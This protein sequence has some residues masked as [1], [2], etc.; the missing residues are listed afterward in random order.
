MTTKKNTNTK[1]IF[2]LIYND[3]TAKKFIKCFEKSSDE[4]DK[5]IY[6]K[7]Y[8]RHDNNNIDDNDDDDDDD[9]V[10]DDVS[11][12]V[13]VIESILTKVIEKKLWKM[14]DDKS[15]DFYDRDN[16]N[17][18]S[19]GDRVK[20]TYIPSSQKY[21]DFYQKENFVGEI[22]FVDSENDNAFFLVHKPKHLE[23]DTN[24][25]TIIV[26]KSLERV[27]SHYLGMTRGYYY[28][29]EDAKK[30]EV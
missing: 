10:D 27:G 17:G 14:N 25:D 5:K 1:Y 30:I 21:I 12:D 23:E 15:N 9:D 24:S 3:Q 8:D 6:D 16:I 11:D 22:I 19:K 18:F 13:D 26:V 28:W 4:C 20:V 29:M 2:D 7:I